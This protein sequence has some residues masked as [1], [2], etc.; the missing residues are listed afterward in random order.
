MV[1]SSG[2]MGREFEPKKHI[3]DLESAPSLD[4]VHLF[5]RTVDTLF[6]NDVSV[7]LPASSS[8]PEKHLLQYIGGDVRAGMC[9]IPFHWTTI[10]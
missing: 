9:S 5:N 3:G 10:L 7:K 1:I 4:D 6:W 8:K 2:S